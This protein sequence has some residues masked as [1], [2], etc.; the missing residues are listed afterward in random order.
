M[1]KNSKCLPRTKKN[2]RS[3]II[4]FLF[5]LTKEEQVQEIRSLGQTN[6]MLFHVCVLTCQRKLIINNLVLQ[7]FGQYISYTLELL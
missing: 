5:D 4:S 6:S 3:R 1:L 7:C 2:K